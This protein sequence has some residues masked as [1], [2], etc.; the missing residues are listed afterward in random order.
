MKDLQ[1]KSI[2]NMGQFEEN[3]ILVTGMTNPDWVPIMGLERALA[4]DEL[5]NRITFQ[6][7]HITNLSKQEDFGSVRGIYCLLFSEIKTVK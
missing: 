2:K 5:F 6:T 4:H 3:N 7:F 1:I